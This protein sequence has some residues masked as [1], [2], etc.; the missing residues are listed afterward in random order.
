MN[1]P[2]CRWGFLGAANIARKNWLAVRNAGN[3]NLAAVASR[4][5]NRA[6]RFVDQCQSIHPF[7]VAPDP[8]DG[9]E[10][11]LDRDDIDAVYIPLPT[12]TRL[13]W[14]IRAAEA[15]KHV[16]CEK[17]C[18]AS[19]QELRAMIDACEAANVQ[20][21][22]GVMFSHSRRF[23]DMR[24]VL[25]RGVPVGKIRRIASHF[26]FNGGPDFEAN[27]IRLRSDLE[28][29]GALGDLGWYNIRFVLWAMNGKLP[30]SARGQFV[31]T[32]QREDSPKPV[33]MEV[34]ADLLFDDGTTASFY[35]SFDVGL[36]QWATVSGDAGYLHVPSFVLPIRGDRPSYRIGRSVATEAGCEVRV[37]D[38][39]REVLVDESSDGQADSQETE[40]FR[41]FSAIA[42]SGKP[43]PRWP[44]L[45]WKTQVVMDAVAASAARGGI[46]IPIAS[47]ES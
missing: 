33:P 27:N 39:G 13:P 30:T 14:V 23:A 4:D 21:M 28:P 10:T 45:A 11:L 42:C 1:E 22:D 6:E 26:S 29:F 20:F 44:A 7:D 40:L 31:R 37:E 12:A 46:Q 19:G 5:V 35:N 36:N 15:G 17:P 43:E 2:V 24:T 34:I 32:L 18:A 16:L 9:Y 47:V 41:T 8:I 3:A 25:D 38:S